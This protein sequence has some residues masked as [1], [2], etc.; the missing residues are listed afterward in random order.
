MTRGALLACVIAIAACG[1]KKRQQRTSDAAPVEPI[2]APSI[3][4]GGAAKGTSDEIE[5]NDTQDTAMELAPGS[6][7]HGRVEPVDTDTDSFRIE[8]AEAGVL[9]LDL[10]AVPQTDLILEL[11]D[12]GGVVVARSDRLLPNV[13]E[14]IPNFAV[15]KGRYTAVVKG[16]KVLIKGKPLKPA[17]PILP[18]DLSAQLVK[19]VAN[20]EREPNDDRGTANDLIVGDGVTGW[21]GWTADADVWKLSIEALSAKNTLDIEIGAVESVALT[22]ELAD[23][24]G[25]PLLVRKGPRGAGLNVRGLHLDVTDGAPPF[26]YLTVKGAPS[27]PDTAYSLRAVPKNLETDAELE[28]NDTIEKPMPI[29]DDRTV[30]NAQWSPGDIDCFA[31]TPE[32]GNRMLEITID[33]PGEADL[34]AELVVDGKVIAKSETKGKGVA[35]KLKGAV[36][37]NAKAIIRVHGSDTGG[38]GSYEIKVVEGGN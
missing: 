26:H 10:G 12:A 9:A 3:A 7:I 28:P 8:I 19:A 4:D 38:E 24:V 6:S 25:K 37:P 35:E 1:S 27:N 30:V 5:P 23:A 14:G 34:S 16:R 11:H 29:P 15:T 17:P 2:T 36:P 13:K 33:V 22:F 32:A 18:Y 21:I 31:V 20:A